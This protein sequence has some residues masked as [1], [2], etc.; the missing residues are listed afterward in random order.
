M[1]STDTRLVRCWRLTEIKQSH[2]PK[3]VAGYALPDQLHAEQVDSKFHSSNPIANSTLPLTCLR[4]VT[5]SS[6]EKPNSI[7][8]AIDCSVTG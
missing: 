5:A 4:A 8:C 7:T 3:N 2:I 6:L 1:I